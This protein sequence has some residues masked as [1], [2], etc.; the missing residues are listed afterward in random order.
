M[1]FFNGQQLDQY[2][3]DEALDAYITT[4]LRYFLTEFESRVLR[5]A[6]IRE[7][8]N[9]VGEPTASK[10]NER[11]A[12]E[13]TDVIAAASVGYNSVREE[14]RK[15]VRLAINNNEVSVNRCPDCQRI[16]RTPAAKQ[17]LWCGHDWHHS[18]PNKN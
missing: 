11:I 4:H 10:L 2:N 13:T 7:K 5:V 8:A 3:E 6:G 18:D 1:P 15:R 14:I 9:H 12:E 17:C 16:V